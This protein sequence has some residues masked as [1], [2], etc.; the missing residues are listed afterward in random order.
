MQFGQQTKRKHRLFLTDARQNYK[1]I[2]KK[3]NPIR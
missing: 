2:L 1:I 3:R